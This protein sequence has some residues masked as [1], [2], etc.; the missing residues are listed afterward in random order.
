M[1][2]GS[3]GE[4][5]VLFFFYLDLEKKTPPVTLS[6]SPKSWLNL[7]SE[8]CLGFHHTFL[9]EGTRPQ[10][11]TGNGCVQSLNSCRKNVRQ[12]GQMRAC[13]TRFA[14]GCLFSWTWWLRLCVPASNWVVTDR[15]WAA[16]DTLETNPTPGFRQRFA[17][18]DETDQGGDGVMSTD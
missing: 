12:E 15:K 5:H 2:P 14:V 11:R 3:L 10:Q 18:K 17:M 8:I 16:N 1:P 9:W 13:G 6:L 7:V 4:G